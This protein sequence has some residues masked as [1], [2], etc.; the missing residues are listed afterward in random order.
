[1]KFSWNKN[2]WKALKAGLISAGTIAAF[3]GVEVLLQSFDTGEELGAI[4]IPVMVIPVIVAVVASLKNYLK[5]QKGSK[6]AQF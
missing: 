5:V 2:V 6:L 1:M 4:G 3:A